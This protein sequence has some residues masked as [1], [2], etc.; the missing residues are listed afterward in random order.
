MALGV[1]QSKILGKIHLADMDVGGYSL[2][3]FHSYGRQ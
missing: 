3:Q 1:G 2:M